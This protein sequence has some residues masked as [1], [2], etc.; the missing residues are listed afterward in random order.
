MTGSSESAV[1]SLFH[2]LSSGWTKMLRCHDLKYSATYRKED[3]KSSRPLE[4]TQQKIHIAD[5]G[6][7]CIERNS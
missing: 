6:T 7:I 5:T 4:T 1:V 2:L 3:R